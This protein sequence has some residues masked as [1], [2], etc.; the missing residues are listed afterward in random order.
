MRTSP[1]EA[2]ISDPTAAHTIYRIKGEFL[3]S[4]WYD[5]L[6]LGVPNVFNATD[7]NVHRRR[8]RLLSQPLSESGLRS[9]IP[10]IDGKI[11]KAI[12]KMA[13]EM[14]ERGAADMYKWW[15]F[16]ATD[17]IGALSFGDCFQMLDKGEVRGI[18][19]EFFCFLV[20]FSFLLPSKPMLL[21]VSQ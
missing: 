20:L 5:S 21:Q 12:D 3:K 16:M 9:L 18:S 15:L 19:F 1:H 8:R 10:I 2:D 4:P 14:N 11:Q 7:P 13:W 17:I 6:V